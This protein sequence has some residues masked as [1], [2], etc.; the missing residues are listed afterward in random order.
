MAIQGAP[1][2]LR[3]QNPNAQQMPAF[4]MNNFNGQGNMQIGN[5]GGG[6]LLDGLGGLVNNVNNN[7]VQGNMGGGFQTGFGSAQQDFWNFEQDNRGT[8]GD[9]K[10]AFEAYVQANPN[11]NP[12][13]VNDYRGMLTAPMSQATGSAPQG[14]PYT[15][16]TLTGPAASTSGPS[17]TVAYGGALLGGLLGNDL[18]G[19]LQAAGGYYAGQQ[20]IE[21]AMATGQAGLDLGESMGKR[22]YDQSQFR[23]FG[24]TSNLANVQTTAEGGVNLNLSPEQQAMQN[25]LLGGAGNLAGNLG[26][27][28]DPRVGQIG[29][30]AF[31][32]AQ[33]Q[34]G[35]VGA[36][37]PSMAAQR[38]A[39]GGLFGQSLGQ[40]GQP[41]GMEGLTQAGLTG[42]QAQLGAAGQPAD[43][44]ALRAQ[45]AGLAGA[46]GQGLLTSPEAKQS[47]IYDAI[48]ATQ[49]PEEERQRLALEERMLS[50]GRLGLGSSAYGGSSPE[51]LAQETA[52]QEAMASAG[53]SARQQAMAEQQQGLATAQGLTGL[54]SGLAGQ[55]S[56]LETA[57]I[58]RGSALANIGM[59][60]QQAGTQMS[61]QQLQNILA[62]QGAD[63]SAAGQQQALQQG[64][65]GLGAGLF[66]LGTQASQLPSQLQGADLANMA[67]MMQAGYQPQRQAIDLFGASGVPSQLAAKGQL[68]G[69]E[70]QSQAGG[71]GLESYMQGANMANLLQQQQLQGLMTGAVGKP[72]TAQEQLMNAMIG[73]LGG[74]PIEAGG[75]MLGG[76]LDWGKD[77][78]GFGGGGTDY[79]QGFDQYMDTSFEDN[80]DYTG[81]PY[82][83]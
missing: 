79:N 31:G 38:S 52:R 57:G 24:V 25:Q 26:S 61:Q 44:E 42:A 40:Y 2:R 73:K 39:V 72:L 63:Q 20:G 5:M 68:G 47:E 4:P 11:L 51:L 56:D 55:S 3:G 49:A 1:R 29:G 10:A 69:A 43:I 70:L 21:G 19:A 59:S 58:S 28:Y 35:Q 32:Q 37:D 54:A 66:G 48:R 8:Y 34:L 22:A 78:L 80:A 33:Q 65:L 7:Q 15:T 30:Q 74:T 82:D 81:S 16:S 64:R 75:G 13:F 18:S 71:R 27:T 6:G 76:V 83:Y 62:L 36:V 67:A 46:A 53:L 45:Y 12:S 14:S 9:D 23:P 17:N 60:G 41:T 77:L 50:Q